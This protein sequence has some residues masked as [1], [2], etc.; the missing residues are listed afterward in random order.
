MASYRFTVSDDKADTRELSRFLEGLKPRDR[1]RIILLALN[2]FCKRINYTMPAGGIYEIIVNMLSE[3]NVAPVA[4]GEPINFAYSQ[5]TASNQTPSPVPEV[6]KTE[7]EVSVK[8]TPD[9]DKE[10]SKCEETGFNSEISSFIMG[11]LEDFD[12]DEDE[13]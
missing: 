9:K 10:M 2:I 3:V 12:F 1:N 8:K 6:S 7:K 11:T 5:Q 13:E 4:R